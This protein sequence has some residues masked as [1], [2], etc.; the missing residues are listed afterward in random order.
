M[1]S[2]IISGSSFCYY[3][4]ASMDPISFLSDLK[5]SMTSTLSFK[6]AEDGSLILNGGAVSKLD[7]HVDDSSG[8]FVVEVV[9]EG[10]R[11]FHN[12]TRLLGL[13]FNEN[14]ILCRLTFT[15][16]V[17][18]RRFFKRIVS[19]AKKLKL[20][21]LIED[22]LGEAFRCTVHFRQ[23]V[24]NVAFY[25]ESSKIEFFLDL[26]NFEDLLKL[27]CFF[28]YAFKKSIGRRLLSSLKIR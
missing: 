13:M 20:R 1:C 25:C 18:D 5:S 23:S 10:F 14:L 11:S 21:G 8:R 7:V 3:K 22:S 24:F 26:K 6:Y 17:L 28:D 2:L 27:K 9:F 12:L 19:R 15:V 16:N 4:L